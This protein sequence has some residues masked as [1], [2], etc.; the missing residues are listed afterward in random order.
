MHFFLS[1]IKNSYIRLHPLQKNATHRYFTRANKQR[2]MSDFEQE[3]TTTREALA[4]LQGQM[5]TILE[6]LQAQRD[7]DVIVN[8][9]DVTIVTS[10]ADTT[11][12]V[13]DTI[14][15]VVQP[16][17]VSQPLSQVGPSK[18]VVAYPW[19]MPHNYN[20]QFST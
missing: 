8:Q 16:T 9:T 12:V 19:G 7:N 1:E 17:I 18:F 4:Q 5:G 2:I 15:P 3:N 6:H 10:A 14:D 13:M 11:L 20:L